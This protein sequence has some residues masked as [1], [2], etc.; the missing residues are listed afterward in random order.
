MQNNKLE[1][2]IF[3]TILAEILRK[4]KNTDFSCHK[5]III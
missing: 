2:A 4:K 5:T 3:K 1:H